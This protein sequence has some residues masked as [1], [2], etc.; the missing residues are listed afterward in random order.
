MRRARAS[1]EPGDGRDPCRRRRGDD[2]LARRTGAIAGDAQDRAVRAP[3]GVARGRR[4]PV[5]RLQ[6]HRLARTRPRR[7]AARVPV[8]RPDLRARRHARRLLAHGAR[9][10]RRGLSRRRPDPQ[11]LQLPPHAGG[12]DDGKRRARDRL[13]GVR[14]RRR[15]HRAAAAGDRG[16]QAARLHRHAELPEDPAREGGRD[17][18]LGRHA[19]P[20]RWSAAKRFRRACATGWPSAASPATKAT[21]PPT[22]ASSPTKPKRAKGCC[23]TKACSS[24]SSGRAPAIRYRTA[25]SARWSSPR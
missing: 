12:R 8:A 15:Q 25:R 23:S 2:H 22:S 13:H 3:E 11:Q 6:R 21:P 17:G 14:R 20:R 1:G 10:L 19:S 9:H 16:A 24:R 5:R 18:H 4:R 7:R